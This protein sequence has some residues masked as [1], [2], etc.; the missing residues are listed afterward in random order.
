MRK[1][2]LFAL[3]L[4]TATATFAQQQQ[5]RSPRPSPST[6]I[7]QTVGITDVTV[8]YSRPGVKGRAI[9]GALVPYDKVWRTGA[10]EA[11]IIT[12]SDDVSIEGQKLPKGTYSLHTVPGQSQWAVIFNKVANQWG[13]Y[14]YDPAQDAVRVNVTPM[15]AP[16][17]EWLTIDF[18]ELTTDTAKMRIHWEKVA[19][20]VTINT[21]TTARTLAQFRN[22]MKPDWR[23]AYMAADFAFENNAA[24]PAEINQWLDQS[25]AVNQ[26]IANLWLKARMQRKAGNLAAARATA[27]QA[28]AAATD[29]QKDFANEINRQVGEWK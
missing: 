2:I 7:T 18:P 26:N 8:K 5:I 14:S 10:N 15:P 19:V 6:T 17:A 13:S 1:S 20:P 23:T 3:C 29:Q 21:D 25:L 9:W 11:T 22:A 28:V 24:T 16:H 12:F 27:Q 4:A